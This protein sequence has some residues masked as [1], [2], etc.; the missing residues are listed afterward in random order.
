MRLHKVAFVAA[1]ALLG[2]TALA[3]ADPFPHLN[4]QTKTPDKDSNEDSTLTE[5]PKP[6]RGVRLS[7]EPV[8]GGVTFKFTTVDKGELADLR[9]L[10]REAAT[11]I[12]YHTKLGALHPE[13]RQS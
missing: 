11:L 6:L 4:D 1:F 8:N 9:V 3:S 5:C 7:L 2:S 10:L 12:E 13:E